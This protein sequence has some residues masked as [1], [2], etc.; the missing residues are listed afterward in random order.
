MSDDPRRA[1]GADL[2]EW[3]AATAARFGVDPQVLDVEHLLQVSGDVAHNVARPAVPVTMFLAGLV[4][5]QRGPEGYADVLAEVEAA[6][7]AW[8]AEEGSA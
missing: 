8:G 4:A 7:V 5:A 3:I 6:A 2:P 1:P